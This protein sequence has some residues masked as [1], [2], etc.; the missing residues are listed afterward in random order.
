[1]T[2]LDHEEWV[3]G[4]AGSALRDVANPHGYRQPDQP[5]RAESA[6]PGRSILAEPEDRRRLLHTALTVAAAI[7]LVAGLREVWYDAVP[8]HLA[9]AVF[10]VA[11]FPLLVAAVVVS[12]AAE[13]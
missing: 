2:R 4:K 13:D 9:F 10:A 8:R 12:S 3:I 11:A 5:E 7:V 1:M 6:L